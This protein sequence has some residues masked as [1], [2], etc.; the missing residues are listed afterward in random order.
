MERKEDVLPL[1]ICA[2]ARK[3][4]HNYPSP[5]NLEV[6]ILHE[7]LNLHNNTRLVF[8]EQDHTTIRVKEF[9]YK[10]KRGIHI[11]VI[12][13]VPMWDDGRGVRHMRNMGIGR[14]F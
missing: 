14:I 5:R 13:H 3:V 7:Q 2:L 4:V 12:I 10:T 11:I 6:V 9:V 1:E 8:V